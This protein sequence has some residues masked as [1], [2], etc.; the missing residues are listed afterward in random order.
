MTVSL[1]QL[2]AGVRQVESGGNYSVVNSIGAV[3]AYQVMKANIP[4]WTRKAL[5]YSMTWQQ[6]RDSRAAQDKVAQV[7]LGGYFAKYGAA[8]AAS[9]WFSGQPNPNSSR[10]DGGNTVSQYVAKV[11]AA[12]GG[13]AD[14]G[15]DLGTGSGGTAV[16]PKLSMDEL[17]SQY[18]LSSALINSSSELKS[19]FKKAVSGSWSADLF[20]AKLKNT[21]WWSTQS[22]T[23]RQYITLKYTD[24]ATWKQ[25]WTAGEAAMNALAVQ[26]GL[27]SQISKGH[28]NKLL[29]D[30][31]YAS[32]ALGW[33]DD[34]IKDWMGSKV[35][36]HGGVMWGEAGQAF[37]QLHSIAYLNGMKYSGWYTTEARA[38]ASGKAT[39]EQAEAAIRAQ[40]AAK[41]SAFADQVKAGQNVMDLA[42]PYI[43]SVAKILE[44]P[45]TDIGLTNSHVSKAMTANKGGQATSIWEFENSLRQDPTW[46]KTQNAQD[47]AMST[48][49]QV[50]QS[51]GMVF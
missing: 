29:Q 31:I 10:S 4:S 36:T 5:G 33:T 22:D 16:T 48:A 11:L 26:V 45:D 1:A 18:G 9:M 15:S 47:S 43:Q 20:S 3:G 42:S 14:T 37:D 50:L 8:G 40:A 44:V 12:A 17:A 13:S 24:P 25:K 49:H 51:F 39:I 27:G 2:L 19:L 38:I 23:L 34:R 21:K 32:L 46:K 6:F 35:S 41:Y 28:S 7:I 30:A